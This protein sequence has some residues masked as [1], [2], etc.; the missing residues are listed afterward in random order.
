MNETIQL[1]FENGQKQIDMEI[2]REYVHVSGDDTVI[3]SGTLVEGIGN[4]QSDLDVYVICDQISTYGEIKEYGHSMYHNPDMMHCQNDTELVRRTLDYIPGDPTHLEVEYWMFDEVATLKKKIE[5]QFEYISSQADVTSISP[6]SSGEEKLFHRCNVGV[7]LETGKSL[8]DRIFS[9]KHREMYNFL[10]YRR[11]G[12]FFWMFKD[13]LG[14]M[15]SKDSHYILEMT[16]NYLIEQVIALYTVSGVTN[17]NMRWFPAYLKR[18]GKQSFGDLPVRATTMLYDLPN[19]ERGRFQYPNIVFP[20]LDEIAGYVR[21]HLNNSD[22]MP[23]CAETLVQLHA[24]K[25]ERIAGNP[26]LAGERLF[27]EE[28]DFREGILLGN[29]FT[30]AGFI[31]RNL[32]WI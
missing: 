2:I 26:C 13:V 8:R 17:P 6:F 10:T 11:F 29:G 32:N 24:E 14:A 28:F 23:S 7:D 9:E 27:Q 15:Q 12:S 4:H 16:R 25:R 31:E 5:A 1:K 21:E 19:T 20:I 3:V 30:H 18:L 22:V